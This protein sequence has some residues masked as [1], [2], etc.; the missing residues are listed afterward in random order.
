MT[1]ADDSRTLRIFPIQH[2]RSSKRYCSACFTC[3]QSRP[4]ASPKLL[5]CFHTE[6]NGS[7]DFS[8]RTSLRP[9]RC[10]SCAIPTRP[11]SWRRGLTQKASW[12][13]LATQTSSRQTNISVSSRKRKNRPPTR[14]RVY[15][16]R[17]CE[18]AAKKRGKLRAR[19]SSFSKKLDF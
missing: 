9:A 13:I 16:S 14:W 19:K 8:T 1:V 5:F 7:R 17:H 10:I 3:H 18:S 12:V 2:V 11:C 15:S 6:T 4:H